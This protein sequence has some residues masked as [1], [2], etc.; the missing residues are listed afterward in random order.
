MGVVG[1]QSSDNFI[2]RQVKLSAV[3]FKRDPGGLTEE[4]EINI[5]GESIAGH[6]QIIG[7]ET[8]TGCNL[9]HISI[10]MTK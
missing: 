5:K 8:S 1:I 7:K 3:R 9:A 10:G 2:I 6:Y 4:L